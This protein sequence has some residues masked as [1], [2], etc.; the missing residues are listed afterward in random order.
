MDLRDRPAVQSK[1]HCPVCGEAAGFNYFTCPDHDRKMRVV[2][3][4]LHHASCVAR[5]SWPDIEP[6]THPVPR[7]EPL[8]PADA[9]RHT[10]HAALMVLRLPDRV[11]A[12]LRE[13]GGISEEV[14]AQVRRA[15][16]YAISDKGCQ[17]A[18]ED[19]AWAQMIAWER[20]E[21]S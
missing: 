20:H 14:L 9:L 16:L 18:D 21:W 8:A 3:T 10:I 5:S 17:L 19:E 11:V 15:L 6:P 12:R 13:Q 2:E 7:R 1:R 4:L